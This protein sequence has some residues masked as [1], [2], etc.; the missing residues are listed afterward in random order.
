[1]QCEETKCIVGVFVRHNRGEVT[2]AAVAIHGISVCAYR[3]FAVD[4]DA[5]CLR[6]PRMR[7]VALSGP[8]M[9]LVA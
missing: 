8:E 6:P 9:P 4:V 7:H 1:M 3:M 2:S 5:E